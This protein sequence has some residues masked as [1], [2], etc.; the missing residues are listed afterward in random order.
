MTN[1]QGQQTIWERVKNTW[2]QNLWT[3]IS[4]LIG[5]FL[6]IA[7]FFI[8][9][10]G[11]IDPSVLAATGELTIAAGVIS[12]FDS[13]NRNTKANMRIRD[14]EIELEREREAE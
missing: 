6:I 7:S 11:V 9:P 12:F 10:K 1:R 14:L 5:T 2:V 8:P 3:R 4:F 13:L